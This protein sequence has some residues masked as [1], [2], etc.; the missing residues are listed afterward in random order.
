M[1]PKW[2]DHVKQA[3][4]IAWRYSYD[5]PG[6]VDHADLIQDCKI[7][8]LE[9]CQTFDP[10]KGVKFSTHVHWTMTKHVLN[11]LNSQ[12]RHWKAKESEGFDN[13]EM[14]LPTDLVEHLREVDSDVRHVVDHILSDDQPWWGFIAEADCRTIRRTRIRKALERWLTEYEGWS[15]NRVKT[16][17]KRIEREL[18]E[19]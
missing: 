16:A 1:E 17:F 12:R 3:H 11:D 5:L 18:V 8:F 7:G 19:A 4:A 15:R 10:E 9:A 2:E 14:Q 6:G 13:A